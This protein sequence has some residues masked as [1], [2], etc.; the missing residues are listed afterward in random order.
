MLELA[1]QQLLWLDKIIPFHRRQ[2][3]N[4]QFQFL[5]N[6]S[7]CN[8]DNVSSQW[9][10]CKSLR[11]PLH[12]FFFQLRFM[13]FAIW[14]KIR[15]REKNAMWCVNQSVSAS[16]SNRPC[17]LHSIRIDNSHH[18]IDTWKLNGEGENFQ[19]ISFQ[20]ARS[21]LRTKGFSALTVTAAVAWGLTTSK[22][23]QKWLNFVMLEGLIR[24]WVTNCNNVNC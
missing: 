7:E 16:A 13:W 5:T 2:Q 12:R 4:F 23:E 15:D 20:F 9:R 3:H 1:L 19:K 6:V 22:R 21:S 14:C 10:W 17:T 11:I 24:S 18:N 8:F